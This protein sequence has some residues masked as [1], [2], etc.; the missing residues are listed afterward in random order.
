M[1]AFLFSIIISLARGLIL[2]IIGT[3]IYLIYQKIKYNN[4]DVNTNFKIFC[5][6]TFC[7]FFGLITIMAFLF[8]FIVW[9]IA[10]A[11]EKRSIKDITKRYLIA[12]TPIVTTII[13]FIIQYGRLNQ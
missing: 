6:I 2:G 1:E 9:L 8:S 3:M 12:Y 10:I 13:F 11:F 5:Y 4:I 7:G